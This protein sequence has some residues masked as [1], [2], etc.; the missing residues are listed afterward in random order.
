[1]KLSFCPDLSGSE[2][3]QLE[4]DPESSLP[5]GRQVQDDTKKLGHHII[6]E[7]P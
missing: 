6:L 2:S 3:H 4:E 7:Y 1:M 5:D